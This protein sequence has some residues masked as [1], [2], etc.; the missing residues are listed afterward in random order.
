MELVSIIVPCYN[1]GATI[2]KTIASIKNQVYKNIEIVV[3]DDGSDCKLTIDLLNSLSGVRLVRQK[4]KGLSAAR[5][6]GI[7]LSNGEFI[8]PLDA[9]DWMHPDMVAKLLAALQNQP[10]LYSY[11]DTVLENE[12]SGLLCKEYNFYE[13]LFLNQLPYCLF[14]HKDLWRSVGGYDESMKFGYEDWEFNI[15]MGKMGYF[16]V[17]VS[18]ALFHYRVSKNGMLISKSNQMHAYIWKS[19]QEKHPDLYSIKSIYRNWINWKNK[20]SANNISIYIILFT[21]HKVFP[22][23]IFSIFFKVMRRRKK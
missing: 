16:P 15:R 6:V 20:P 21:L 5:N 7:E 14:F 10:N 3:V 22:K 2:E 4:N 9:D 23:K 19:I 8:L 1:S 13:Q 12:R 18:Q 17:H 11:C